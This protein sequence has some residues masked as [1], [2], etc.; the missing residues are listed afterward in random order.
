MFE[1]VVLKIEKAVQKTL[2]L[3]ELAN[4]HTIGELVE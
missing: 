3:V 4:V 2:K 1:E